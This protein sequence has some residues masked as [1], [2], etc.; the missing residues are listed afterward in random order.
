MSGEAIFDPENEHF[1]D[2]ATFWQ[3]LK[4]TTI[5]NLYRKKR[6]LRQT[7]NVSNS[8]LFIIF[9]AGYVSPHATLGC[10]L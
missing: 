7:I 10:L 1:K 8:F 2:D 3:Q 4:A 9:Y 6:G 5:R